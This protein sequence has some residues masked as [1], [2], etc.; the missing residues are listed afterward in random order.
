MISLDEYR[1]RVQAAFENHAMAAATG[2]MM[3]H[4]GWLPIVEKLLTYIASEPKLADARF[5][6]F[7]D[8]EG[9][10][11]YAHFESDS[12]DHIAA[13]AVSAAEQATDCACVACGEPGRERHYGTFPL[14]LNIIACD[15]HASPEI[16]DLLTPYW[17]VLREEYR[18]TQLAQQTVT[19]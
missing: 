17:N 2:D 4:P 18:Q 3:I 19:P 14:S 11:L 6:R 13:T 15:A 16:F 1:H 7:Q 9:G 12:H 5:T 8:K 10:G